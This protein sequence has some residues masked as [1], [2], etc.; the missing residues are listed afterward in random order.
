MDFFLLLPT[1]TLHLHLLPSSPPSSA[2]SLSFFSLACPLAFS[3]S[4][5]A[6]PLSYSFSFPIP[7]PSSVY[8]IL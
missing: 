4:S 6:C 5:S 2:C 3:L 1:L 7:F 8:N